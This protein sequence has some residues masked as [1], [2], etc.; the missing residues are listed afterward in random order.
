MCDIDMGHFANQNLSVAVVRCWYSECVV[1]D[2]TSTCSVYCNPA[3]DDWIYDC[4]LTAM[5]A[6]QAADALASVLF[7]GDLNGHH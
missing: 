4:L 3:L 1:L 6:V 2:R 5:A 7:V